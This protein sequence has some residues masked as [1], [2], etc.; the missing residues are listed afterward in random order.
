MHVVPPAEDPRSEP[1]LPRDAR[2]GHKRR[3]RSYDDND[4]Y[5]RRRYS[6]LDVLERY[7]YDQYDRYDRYDRYSSSGGLSR[8]RDSYYDSY[9]DRPPPSYS[10]ERSHYSDLDR[11]RYSLRERD[12]YPPRPSSY[13]DRHREDR[14]D[15]YSRR[16]PP[17]SDDYDYYSSRRY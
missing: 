6:R 10:Y 2:D 3:D 13:Y 1:P 17:L 4:E 5:M 9:Y 16:P 8:S 14:Y 11:D 12:H 7:L 15:D